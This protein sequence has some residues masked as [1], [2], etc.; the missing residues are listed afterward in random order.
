MRGSHVRLLH[1]ATV[2]RAV[3][4]TD[5]RADAETHARAL[6]GTDGRTDT[7]AHGWTYG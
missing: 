1:A 2:A 6:V 7:T 3:A 5:V 4:A